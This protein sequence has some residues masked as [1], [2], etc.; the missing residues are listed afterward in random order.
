MSREGSGRL[1]ACGSLVSMY[2]RE[3]ETQQKQLSAV[4]QL[5]HRQNHSNGVNCSLPAAPS[6]ARPAYPQPS[7]RNVLGYRLILNT[8]IALERSVCAFLK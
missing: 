1:R 8:Y 4:H 7:T 2:G 3:Q 5:C 6:G